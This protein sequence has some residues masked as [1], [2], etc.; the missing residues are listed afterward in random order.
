MMCKTENISWA[1]E[2]G[3][4]NQISDDQ[5]AN[6]NSFVL[7]QNPLITGR[8][9][10]KMTEKGEQYQMSILESRRS[11]LVAR[12]TRK[13]SEIE[14]LLYSYHNSFTD[15]EELAQLNDMLK[16]AVDIHE[17]MEMLDDVTVMKYG[18]MNLFP[19]TRYTTG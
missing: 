12:L 5:R 2:V 16:L 7:W 13:L 9:Q 6:I 1:N 14:M 3:G 4:Q 17:E 18:L 10:H 15:R 8:R 19:S 11:K